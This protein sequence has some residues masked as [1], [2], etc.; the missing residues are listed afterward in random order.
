[1]ENNS[2]MLRFKWHFICHFDMIDNWGGLAQSINTLTSTRHANIVE[3]A[4]E[5]LQGE[6]GLMQI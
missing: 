2:W 3:H 6:M 5:A 1:M 4:F